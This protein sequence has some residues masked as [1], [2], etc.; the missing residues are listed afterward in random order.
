LGYSF[1]FLDDKPLSFIGETPD[2]NLSKGMRQLNAAIKWYLYAVG[3]PKISPSW[4]SI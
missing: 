4:A 2:A 1:I 3:E